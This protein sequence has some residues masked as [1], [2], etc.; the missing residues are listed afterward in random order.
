M[1]E[2]VCTFGMSTSFDQTTRS[3]IPEDRRH[4]HRGEYLMSPKFFFAVST[5]N[6]R[7]VTSAIW[8]L[9]IK[10]RHCLSHE[11]HNQV[12]SNGNPDTVLTRRQIPWKQLCHRITERKFLNSHL[13][14]IHLRFSR[15]C[16]CYKHGN[17]MSSQFR[18]VLNNYTPRTL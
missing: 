17:N 18:K 6:S 11:F 1:M 7:H 14:Y 2:T 16:R 3:N 13:K 5:L 9:A 4:T 8:C 15:M 12:S 10:P